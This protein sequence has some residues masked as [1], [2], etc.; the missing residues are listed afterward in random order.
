MNELYRCHCGVVA[1]QLA[2]NTRSTERWLCSTILRRNSNENSIQ[3]TIHLTHV[4]LHPNS[5]SNWHRSIEIILHDAKMK[6]SKNPLRFRR[7]RWFSLWRCPWNWNQFIISLGMI[8]LNQ[9]QNPTTQT[10]FT[11]PATGRQRRATNKTKKK[12]VVLCGE[13]LRLF[14]QRKEKNNAVPDNAR[15]TQKFCFFFCFVVKK[16]DFWWFCCVFDILGGKRMMVLIFWTAKG[17]I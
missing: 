4:R 15:T 2:F 5:N 7:F 6:I 8:V 9:R 1:S 11:S 14:V 16:I 10:T 3:T 13:S 17:D 12:T